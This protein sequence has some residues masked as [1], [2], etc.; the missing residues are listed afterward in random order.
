MYIYT[1]VDLLKSHLAARNKLIKDARAL[2]SKD[3]P[4]PVA[5]ERELAVQLNQI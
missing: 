3:L 2:I 4:R 1:C 5:D